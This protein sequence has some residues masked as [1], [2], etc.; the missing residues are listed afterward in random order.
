MGKLEN[1]YRSNSKL[2]AGMVIKSGECTKLSLWSV[3][4]NCTARIKFSQNQLCL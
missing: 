4:D 3:M 1:T 2:M